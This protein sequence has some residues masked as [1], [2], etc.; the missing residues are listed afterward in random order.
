MSVNGGS[1]TTSTAVEL[2]LGEAERDLLDQ[3]DR[4]EVVEVHLPVA[5]DQRPAAGRGGARGMSVHAHSQHRDAGQRLALEV[6]QARAAA[7]GDVAEARPRRCRA[8]GRPPPSRRRRRRSAR[9][10]PPRP[11]RRRGCP[12]E[13]RQLEHAHRAVPEHRLRARERRGEQRDG[14]G[15]MSRPIRSAGI[16]SA[17]TTRRRRR[18]RTPSAHDDVG[19]QHDL[20]AGSARAARGRCRPGRPRAASSPTSW[21][22]ALRKVKHMPPPT[23]RLST[24]GSSASMTASL[25]LTL[26]PPSTT[27]Y[28]RSGS[29]VS[30]GSTSTSRATSSP[31]A[32]RQPL[33]T[34]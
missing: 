1:T 2:L 33:A 23:S 17:A 13:R 16:A 26:E 25:S 10:R 9:R 12:G 24:L 30:R 18:R 15:P 4:L 27:A 31:A 3:G 8:R 21:P 19:R 28:G 20:V 22:C 7:G 32:V 14:R 34:S 29:P 11:R 5:G 6:L